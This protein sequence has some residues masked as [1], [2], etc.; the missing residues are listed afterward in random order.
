M[1]CK[2]GVLKT[3][4]KFTG[5]HLRLSLIFNKAA[6]LRHSACNFIEKET[7]AQVLSY[8]FCNISKNTFS[9]RTP[10]V[11]A[12]VWICSKHTSPSINFASRQ[13][14]LSFTQKYLR[15][16][17][18]SNQQNLS[19]SYDSYKIWRGSLFFDIYSGSSH[20]SQLLKALYYFCQNCWLT[21]K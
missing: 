5:K 13:K 15:Q 6:G 21:S 8:E 3:F 16:Y 19:S 12:F 4:T 2:K 17:S 7:L 20:V 1:F 10:P 11:A 14:D 9:Y 18:S